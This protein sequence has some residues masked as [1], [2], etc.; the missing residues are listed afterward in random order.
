M[1][2]KG[3]ASCAGQRRS[4]SDPSV[5][6]VLFYEKKGSGKNNLILIHGFAM[7]RKSWY[8]VSPALAEKFVI[9]MVDLIGS[10]NSPA[11]E[12]WPY[13]MEAQAEAVFDF[14]R[15]KKL[16]N[17]VLIGHSYGG[18]VIFLLLQKMIENGYGAL[19]KK[20][21]LIAPAAYPQPLPFFIAIPCIPFIGRSLLQFVGAEFQIKMT[22]RRVVTNKKAVTQERVKRY[23]NNIT[24]KNY[25]DAL[26]KTAQNI[27]PHEIDS[28]VNQ[29][30]KIGQS[31]LLIY[32]ENDSVILQKNL[33]RLSSNLPDVVTKK[34]SDCGHVPHEEY[35]ELVAGLISEFLSAGN[36]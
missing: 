34:I 27:L 2:F 20:L 11:P 29:I 6:P 5:K 14:I 31:T 35:P 17:V 33:E 32:G 18:G 26:I 36:A 13:T 7:N 30:E 25:R 9:Y 24:K 8:D 1:S 28:I 21:V 23:K 16:S 4:V 15:D 10:G 22:L 19:V 12:N 3:L